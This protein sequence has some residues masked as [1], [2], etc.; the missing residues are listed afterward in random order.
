[1]LDLLLI[2]APINLYLML[3]LGS[4]LTALYWRS[5]TCGINSLVV[6]LVLFSAG[7]ITAVVWHEKR[8]LTEYDINRL[9]TKGIITS[10]ISERLSISDSTFYSSASSITY[11][12][13]NKAANSCGSDN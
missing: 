6:L 12:T 10:C 3:A 5:F 7:L 11:S 4:A 13:I 9:I 2:N 8:Q 1:M